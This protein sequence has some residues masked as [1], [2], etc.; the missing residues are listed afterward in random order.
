MSVSF[1]NILALETATAICAAALFRE[2]QFLHE[3]AELSPQSH[4][5]LLPG[6]VDELLKRAEMASSSIDLVAVS[7]GPGSFSGLRVGL[8]YG[9]GFALGAHAGLIPVNTLEGLARCLYDEV[10]CRNLAV[11]SALVPVTAARKGEVFAQVF[12]SSGGSLSAEGEPFLGG[13]E[14]LRSQ[15]HVPAAVGGIGLKTLLKN[16]EQPLL[17][18]ITLLPD[19]KPSARSI[20]ERAWELW[21]GHETTFNEYDALEPR[22]LKEFTLRAGGRG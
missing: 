22:Y 18:E 14:V 21:Q 16:L 6:M 4:H 10:K 5:E 8:S 11:D 9:K 17:K 2:A 1:P 7:I 13:W 20:G 19:V 3:I 12:S 15:I